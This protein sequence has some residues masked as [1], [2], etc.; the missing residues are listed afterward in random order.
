MVLNRRTRK[1]IKKCDFKKR[2][3]GRWNYQYKGPEAR[4]PDSE[5]Q[6]RVPCGLCRGSRQGGSE[7]IK[8]REVGW[9]EQII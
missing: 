5:G 9:V 6:Q 3:P 7:R 1:V 8:S 2:T 4:V